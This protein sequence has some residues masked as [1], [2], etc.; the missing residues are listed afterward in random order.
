MTASSIVRS[1]SRGAR[2]ASL[3]ASLV[4][5]LATLDAAAANSS[6]LADQTR[7]IHRVPAQCARAAPA[8]CVIIPRSAPDRSLRATVSPVGPT[9]PTPDRRRPPGTDEPRRGHFMHAR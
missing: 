8:R 7:W 5:A 3:I 9:A 6:A 4:G 2:I 1:R